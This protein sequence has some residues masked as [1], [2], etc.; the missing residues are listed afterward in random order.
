MGKKLKLLLHTIPHHARQLPS[1]LVAL[2]LLHS[3]DHVS[4]LCAP[5]HH[6]M[7]SQ[8]DGP[9]KSPCTLALLY[10]VNS[11]WR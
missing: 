6:G 2:P 4:Q 5:V 10:A 7:G 8:S 9:S 11:L 3:H 1:E